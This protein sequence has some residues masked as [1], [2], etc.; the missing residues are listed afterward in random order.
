MPVSSQLTAPGQRERPFSAD[1]GPGKG[2]QAGKKQKGRQRQEEAPGP[3]AHGEVSEVRS[4]SEAR[5]GGTRAA[6]EAQHT[7]KPISES[8]W[9]CPVTPPWAAT[10]RP[11][12]ARVLGRRCEAET[13]RGVSGNTLSCGAAPD[14]AGYLGP[15]G[16]AAASQRPSRSQRE[17]P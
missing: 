15:K 13:S 14:R 11:S 6:W 8:D 3:G 1:S 9:Q 17:R 16:G 10:C 2:L 7:A 5:Q 12:E 4:G